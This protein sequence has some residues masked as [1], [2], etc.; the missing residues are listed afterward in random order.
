MT[1]APTVTYARMAVLSALLILAVYTGLSVARLQREA[2]P[3]PTSEQAA[4]DAAD[5]MSAGVGADIARLS[6]AMTAGGAMAQRFSD[7]PMDAA[8]AALKAAQ[9]S[10]RAVAVVGEDGVLAQ[11]GDVRDADWRGA[12]RAAAASGQSFWLGRLAKGGVYA[13]QA[14]AG[15]GANVGPGG[16]VTL[17]AVT[18]LQA[19]RH[20]VQGARLKA[21]SDLLAMA[22]AA[23]GRPPSSPSRGERR[24]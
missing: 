11:A 7:N 3:A 2:T 17:V 24:R 19:R 18:D 22:V 1:G 4:A 14:V 20:G 8:E 6:A 15:G 9:P 16:R 13:A 21:A 12:A 10:A 5:R 23:P